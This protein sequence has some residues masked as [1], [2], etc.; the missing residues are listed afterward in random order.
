[1]TITNGV[2]GNGA[3]HGYQPS[4]SPTS[5]SLQAEMQE[6][7]NASSQAVL[8]LLSGT[9]VSPDMV[10]ALLRRRIDD[11]DGQIRSLMGAIEQRTSE[12]K[13]IQEKIG[14]M[15]ELAAAVA[16]ADPEGTK[17]LDLADITMPDGSTALEFAEKHGLIDDLGA[18]NGMSDFAQDVTRS[19]VEQ[20]GPI[21][22]DNFDDYIAFARDSVGV[23]T[24]AVSAIGGNVAT[25][26]ARRRDEQAAIDKLEADGFDFSNGPLGA[27]DAIAQKHGGTVNGKQLESKIGA[28]QSEMRAINSGN[29]LDMIKLQ[30]AMQQRSQSITLAT[31]MIKSIHDTEKAIVG[32]F[33]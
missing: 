22:E 28:L 32:N 13:A 30:S 5:D 2:Q 8:S 19:F 24:A 1:M 31:N 18:T 29:E 12:A 17:N 10:L 27:E 16:S 4:A 20:H 23:A 7:A 21:T 26:S 14:H 25:V 3:V 33:R 15:Q 9:G 6:L 11:V